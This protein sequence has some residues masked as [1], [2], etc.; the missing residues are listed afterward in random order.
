MFHV[1]YISRY[2]IHIIYFNIISVP[3]VPT[4]QKL[5][6]CGRA[7][8]HIQGT[9]RKNDISRSKK[10]TAVHGIGGIFRALKRHRRGVYERSRAANEGEE[11]LECAGNERVCQNSGREI[12]CLASRLFIRFLRRCSAVKRPRTKLYSNHNDCFMAC[13][14]RERANERALTFSYGWHP[15]LLRVCRPTVI[16]TIDYPHAPRLLLC[17]KRRARAWAPSNFKGGCTLWPFFL[18]FLFLFLKGYV[19]GCVQGRKQVGIS[20]RSR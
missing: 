3:R 14:I 16:D 12:L 2:F 9:Y 19:S 13:T 4:S 6:A 1:S 18:F 15:D 7:R 11:G 17:S 20:V 5:S 10:H 8:T